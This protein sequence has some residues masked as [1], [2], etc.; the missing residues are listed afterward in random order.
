M[1]MR[2]D[3]T[4]HLVIT[5]DPAS[6]STH[7]RKKE[8]K[9]ERKIVK[10]YEVLVLIF[11]SITNTVIDLIIFFVDVVLFYLLRESIDSLLLFLEG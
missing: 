5:M 11:L 10:K 9:N 3:E 8:K 1:N 2:M 7:K 4:I 6:F